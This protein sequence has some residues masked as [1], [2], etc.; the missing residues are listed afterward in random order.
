MNC[1]VSE[2]KTS[3]T[4]AQEWGRERRAYSTAKC[5]FS[6]EASRSRA[7]VRVIPHRALPVP[8]ACRPGSRTHWS[9]GRG[10]LKVRGSYFWSGGGGEKHGCIP[11]KS[12]IEEKPLEVRGGGARGRPCTLRH[13]LVRVPDKVDSLSLSLYFRL[14]LLLCLHLHPCLYLRLHLHLYRVY[15]IHN[16]L[17]SCAR[18]HFSSYWFPSC[19]LT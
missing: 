2:R 19:V 11:V 6:L 13:L 7:V 18:V 9:P 14:D 1:V 16:Y 17:Q 15:I 5:Q 12:S 4:K 10:F 8:T 3:W